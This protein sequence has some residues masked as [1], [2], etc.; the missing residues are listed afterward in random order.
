MPERKIPEPVQEE[1]HFNYEPQSDVPISSLELNTISKNADVAQLASL[2]I[3]LAGPI[4]RGKVLQE[5]PVH[6]IH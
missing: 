3:S 2:K 5:D 4:Q 6:L 1:S